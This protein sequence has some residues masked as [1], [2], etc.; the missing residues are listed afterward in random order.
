MFG[1]RYRANRVFK[2]NPIFS[3][4]HWRIKRKPLI[5]LYILHGILKKHLYIFKKILYTIIAHDIYLHERIYIMEYLILVLTVIF[6]TA[7][8]MVRKSYDAKHTDTGVFVFGGFACLVSCIF[9]FVSGGFSFNFNPDVLPYALGFAAAYGSTTIFSY[10]AIRTGPLSL[11][12]LITSYSLVIPTLYALAFLGESATVFFW[13]GLVF[14]LISLF[15]IGYEKKNKSENTNGSKISAKWLIFV[16]LAFFGNGM[17]STVQTA[18]QKAFAGQ[19]KSEL[20]IIALAI[21]TVV[22]LLTGALVEK[23]VFISTTKTCIPYTLAYGIING[24]VNLF[25]MILTGGNKISASVVFPTISAGGIIMAAIVS[26]FY[27]KE[28]LNRKQLTALILGT[29]AVILMNL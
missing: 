17:C 18:Q 3:G 2:R 11:T 5:F 9:F 26:V 24:T 12:S 16:S 29:V 8:Q 23:R 19:Y 15:L 22:L 4:L 21:V 27:Y 13:V 10:M 20:M 6:M 7:V 14:L 1:L 28:K 25:V